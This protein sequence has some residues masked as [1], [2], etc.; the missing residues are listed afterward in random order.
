[1][2]H[3]VYVAQTRFIER[4]Q[5]RVQRVCEAFHLSGKDGVGD[6]RELTAAYAGDEAFAVEKALLEAAENIGHRFE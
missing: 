4:L 2:C 1:M 3:R 5:L 6:N